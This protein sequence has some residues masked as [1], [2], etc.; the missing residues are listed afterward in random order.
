MWRRPWGHNMW[1]G[2]GTSQ[3]GSPTLCICVGGLLLSLSALS[4]GPGSECECVSV[5]ERR[6]SF[7][8][9][10]HTCTSG[11]RGWR[12]R[13]WMNT[14]TPEVCGGRIQVTAWLC[15]P[16]PV[17]VSG[18]HSTRPALFSSLLAS[19]P[20]SPTSVCPSLS[21]SLFL[22]FFSCNTNS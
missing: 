15:P 4:M 6:M 10:L 1:L 7:P 5:H 22:S 8:L 16:L 14:H 13:K 18:P 12:P 19:Y 11:H 3:E 2:L 20:S 21:L 17:L 9:C